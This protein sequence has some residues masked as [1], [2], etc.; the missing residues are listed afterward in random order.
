MSKSNNPDFALQTESARELLTRVIPPVKWFIPNLIPEGLTLLAG[1]AKIGKSF[2][3]W[4]IAIAVATGGKAL[5][6]IDI[7]TSH[8]VTYMAMEDPD[9]LLQERLNQICPDQMPN[10]V[11]IAYGFGDKKF[12]NEGLGYIEDHLEKTMTELLIVDTWRHVRPNPQLDNGTSYDNDYAAM[13]PVQRF[14]H[15]KNIAVILVTHT[16]K[17]KHDENPFDQ[18]QGS[19]GMQAG[20]DTMLMLTRDQQSHILHTTGR[21]MAQSELA[22]TFD[23]GIWTIEGD[24]DEFNLSPERKELLKLLY[25]SGSQG[26][27]L[28]EIADWTGRTKAAISKMLGKMVID[29]L[30]VQPQKFK[31]YYH[32]DFYQAGTQ[33]EFDD[34]PL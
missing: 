9:T 29:A 22:M 34:I 20:C 8:N 33:S 16:T 10:N 6:E 2:F 25:E 28:K 4:N 19:T 7:E 13:I 30:V 24:A 27:A 31:N 32:S 18:I 15:Q 14:A 5:S 12:D 1:P 11:H 21:R 3:A 23:N 26:L 17:T